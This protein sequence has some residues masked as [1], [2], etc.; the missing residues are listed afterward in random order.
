MSSACAL[1]AA[2]VSAAIKS[3]VAVGGMEGFVEPVVAGDEDEEEASL[4]PE[5]TARSFGKKAELMSP[6]PGKNSTIKGL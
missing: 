5:E 6:I 2:A 4:V 1:I 3:E